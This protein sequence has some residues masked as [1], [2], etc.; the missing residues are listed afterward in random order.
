MLEIVVAI[1]NTCCVSIV[2]AAYEKSRHV[3]FRLIS[4]PRVL[5]DTPPNYMPFPPLSSFMPIT[6]FPGAL[7]SFAARWLLLCASFSSTAPELSFLPFPSLAWL[8][9]VDCTSMDGLSVVW[10]LSGESVLASVRFRVTDDC[11]M[12]QLRVA[13]YELRVAVGR[14]EDR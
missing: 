5:L 12:K 7:V 10:V 3:I 11:V 1:I 4:S 9:G 13:G 8:E 14:F 6:V 2:Q